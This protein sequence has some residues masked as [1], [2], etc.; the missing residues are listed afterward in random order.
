M[1]KFTAILLVILLVTAVFTGCAPAAPSAPAEPAPAEPTE[2]T[3][4]AP[5]PAD[6]AGIQMGLSLY[7]RDQFFVS[8]ETAMKD[9][10]K[11]YPGMTITT[12]DAA[13]DV[14][15]QLEHITTFATQGYSAIATSLVNPDT[16][17]E[18]IAAAGDI[19]MI[20]QNRMPDT[21]KFTEGK[22]TYIG[23]DETESGKLQ[24]EWLAEH[25]KD[26]GKQTLD[27]VILMGDL[28]LD[29]TTKRTA[30]AKEALEKAGFKLN[31]VFEDTANWSRAE[32]MT[33]MEQILGTGV[34]ID[35]VIANND[36]MAL[37]AIEALKSVNKLEGIPVVGI[38]ATATGVA[39]VQDGE[40]SMT[41]FQNAKAQGEKAVEVA[42]IA[43]SG[44]PIEMFYW[45]PF[46]AVTK[47]NASKYA[48]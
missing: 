16:V 12:F 13:Q 48:N 45:I 33:K 25:F 46:E 19:P 10:A 5:V 9:A 40:M 41:V 2:S 23:S 11:N 28:G 18:I 6:N 8:Q 39:A 44:A 32:A 4:S 22:H 37:G 15:K 30:S 17:A 31:M 38:D 43:A 7:D 20:F 27:I 35:A 29:N 3:D 1:K 47:D 26:S 21:S 42:S 34:N 24:G 36:E 14:Q